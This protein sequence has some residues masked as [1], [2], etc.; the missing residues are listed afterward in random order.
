MF[1][2]DPG[3]GE[4]TKPFCV[5]SSE[6]RKAKPVKLVRWRSQLETRTSRLYL[7]LAVARIVCRHTL[8]DEDNPHN[9]IKMP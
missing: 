1:S 3:L 4:K 6:L 9:N 5:A 8:K 2:G 7:N